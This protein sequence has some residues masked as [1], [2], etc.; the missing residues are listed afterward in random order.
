M[1]KVAAFGMGRVGGEAAYLSAVT[2]FA[3]E[4]VLYDINTELLG[5][6]KLDILHGMDLPV[7]TDYHDMKDAD[8]CIFTAGFSRSPDVKTRADLF[9]KNLPI[10]REAAA[11]LAGFEGKLIVLTNPMDVFTWYFAKHAGLDE[12]Q[13]VG[14]GG[15]LDSRRFTLALHTMGIQEQGMVIGEHGENQ[16]PLFSRLPMEVPESVREE[17]LLGLRGSSMPVIKGKGGTVFGPAYHIEHMLED[18]EHGREIVCSLPANGAY[19]IDGCSIGMP[20]KVTKNGAKINESLKL[21]TWEQAKFT[22]A[23]EFLTGL[24]RR[25]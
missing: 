6:Q 7:S 11:K 4:L 16:V 25:V 20:A 21:D 17:V 8:Y 2:G 10:A 1:T 24:C 9:D 18:I 15:L 14:F 19:G 3:D 5:A 13:V 12:D 22:A 23:A